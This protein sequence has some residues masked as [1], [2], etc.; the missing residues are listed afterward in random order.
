[1]N[2]KTGYMSAA[3]LACL[4]CAPTAHAQRSPWWEKHRDTPQPETPQSQ[5][6]NSAPDEV[7]RQQAPISSSGKDG[8]SLSYNYA[9][10]GYNQVKV[11]FDYLDE[12]AGGGYI[13]GS[14][15][16][17]DHIHLFGSYGKVSKGWSDDYTDLDVDIDQTEI[18]IGYRHGLSDN[19][20]FVSDLSWLRLG[21]KVSLTDIDPDYNLSGSDHLN[22]W[23]LTLGVRSKPSPRSEVW[24][25]GGY[26]Q[27][28]DNLLLDNS[29]VVILGGQINFTPI[30]GLVGEAEIY[31]DISYYRIGIRA[32]Y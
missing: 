31:E 24:L 22:A 30:W 17:S 29:A 14:V 10:A 18:G 6:S 27:V 4:A 3:L 7:S 9:E 28:D 21:A 11:D 5:H 23:K 32:S 19:T 13:R 2:T 16:V 12:N 1:M 8:N 15:A 26:V 20:D 25:K